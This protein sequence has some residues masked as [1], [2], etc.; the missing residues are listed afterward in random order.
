MFFFL[1]TGCL[2]LRINITKPRLLLQD[3]LF[4]RSAKGQLPNGNSEWIFPFHEVRT[5]EAIITHKLGS[6]VISIYLLTQA[7]F[8]AQQ[9]VTVKKPVGRKI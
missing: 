1:F 9:Y 6:V 4:F 7:N 5:F 2:R 8:Q 3:F